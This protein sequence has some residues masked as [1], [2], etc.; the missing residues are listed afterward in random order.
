M[1]EKKK[2]TRKQVIQIGIGVVIFAGGF[3]CGCKFMNF[4]RAFKVFCND[5]K[6]KVIYF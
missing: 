6:V 4:E 1:N 2:L 5:P 3:Y